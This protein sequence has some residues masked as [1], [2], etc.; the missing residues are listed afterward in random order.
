MF[1]SVDE[2]YSMM[3]RTASKQASRGCVHLLR[4]DFLIAFRPNNQTY[5]GAIYAEEVSGD[6]DD[7]TLTNLTVLFD[8]D[9]D[10]WKKAYRI[11]RVNFSEHIHAVE[12]DRIA[13]TFETTATRLSHIRST[14]ARMELREVRKR[15][16]ELF[17]QLQFLNNQVSA[18]KEIIGDDYE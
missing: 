9:K 4:G 2:L 3:R 11:L 10:G 18:L 13:L 12:E 14:M 6:I 5:Q 15:Q 1:N 7:T 17:P 8:C 16:S